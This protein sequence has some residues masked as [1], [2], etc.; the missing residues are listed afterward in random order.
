MWVAT[1]FIVI[2]LRAAS[3]ISAPYPRF[4]SRRRDFNHAFL[5]MDLRGKY[6]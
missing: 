2:S 6:L 1:A 3:L 5:T 4:Q